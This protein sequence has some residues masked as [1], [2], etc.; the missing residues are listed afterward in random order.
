MKYNTSLGGEG[1]Y[2]GY[3]F[4]EL[5]TL[6]TVNEDT[7]ATASRESYAEVQTV[8]G[9]ETYQAM[10]VGLKPS[11]M[12]VLPSWDDDYAGEDLLDYG[13]NRYR[14]IRAYRTED[15]HAEL[16]VTRL[17]PVSESDHRDEV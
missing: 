12:I 5:V 6:V 16:T 9:S 11:L 13:G 15:G 2:R 1:S 4:D 7:G 3:T 10:T 14:V 8:S 17:R